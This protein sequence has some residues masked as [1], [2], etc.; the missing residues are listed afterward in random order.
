MVYGLV[1]GVLEALRDEIDRQHVV[2]EPEIEVAVEDGIVTL[3]GRVASTA[4]K[5]IAERAVKRVPGV[6]SV[7]N[8][9]RV[10]SGRERT[11][12][13][14]AREALHRL[15]NNLAVPVGVQ[16]VVADGFITLDGTVRWMHQRVAAE[17]AVKYIA[18][19][20]GVVN[21]ITL[22]PEHTGRLLGRAF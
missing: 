16:A 3:T 8:D 7:A 6:R 14:I 10:T 17:S 12:T 13:D 1:P 22:T 4:T 18:G 11:D 5:E 21:E 9:L 20:R 2:P 19:V 15:R